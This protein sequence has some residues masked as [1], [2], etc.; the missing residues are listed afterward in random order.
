MLMHNVLIVINSLFVYLFAL[1]VWRQLNFVN[2]AFKVSKKCKFIYL[3][4][5]SLEFIDNEVESINNKSHTSLI[6]FS[7]QEMFYGLQ[8]GMSFNSVYYL[9]SLFFK[10]I[11]KVFGRWSSHFTASTTT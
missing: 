7:L 4:S 10:S 1:K 5:S 6:I 3:F 8:S 2:N 11:E 9:Y